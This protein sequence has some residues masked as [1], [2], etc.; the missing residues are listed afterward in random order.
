[1]FVVIECCCYLV[2]KHSAND[3]QKIDKRL[4]NNWTVSFSMI[5]Y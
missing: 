3:N 1:M 2:T 4:S 5:I